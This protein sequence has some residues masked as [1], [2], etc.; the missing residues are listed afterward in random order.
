MRCA[1]CS[2]SGET[3]G[4]ICWSCLG[5]GFVGLSSSSAHASEISRLRAENEALRAQIAS[6]RDE[7]L[8]DADFDGWWR[9]SKYQQV[10]YLGSPHRQ[11]A[12]DGWNAAIRAIK[13]KEQSNG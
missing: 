9:A 7:T 5:T 3:T 13:T 4:G 1:K 6:I 11:I 10:V 8:E 12:L 2:G